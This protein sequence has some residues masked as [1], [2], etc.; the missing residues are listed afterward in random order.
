LAEV[1]DIE[2]LNEIWTGWMRSG[3]SPPVTVVGVSNGRRPMLP[4]GLA[5][6][7]LA[8]IRSGV[9]PRDALLDDLGGA[10]DPDA[11]PVSVIDFLRSYFAPSLFAPRPWRPCV[12][13]IHQV[14][15]LFARSTRVMVIIGA[16]ASVGPDF[17]SPG[18]LY[19]MIAR[20]HAL[21]DPYQV[22]D[23]DYFRQ[24]PTVFWRF[25]HLIFPA[26]EPDHSQTHFFLA[27]LEANGKLL[28]VYSQNVDTL[29]V[30]IPDAKL[31]C[32]HGSWR[33]N[34][35]VEC[36]EVLGIEDLRGRV[37]RQEVPVCKECGGAIKPGIV[38]FGQR[39]NIEDEDIDFDSQNADLLVVIGTSLR[40]AP[41]S[42]LP[43]IMRGIPAVLINREPVTCTFSAEMLGDCDEIC[44]AIEKELGWRDNARPI[45]DFVFAE[46]NKFLLAASGGVGTRFVETGRNLFIVTPTLSGTDYTE[47]E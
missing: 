23:L 43:R 40:V 45:G 32:V 28:R 30:G 26:V 39:T 19:D 36:G 34:Q 41:V 25:A 20:A 4:L 13:D 5:E 16:G 7:I 24:D 14:V 11:A 38:F 21:D 42:Y 27:N 44:Q 31:R 8:A 10:R 1:E 47:L 29:E 12:T 9:G 37:E 35:C 17:R 33:H 18:G 46:P 22:F 3:V 6:R 2:Q 15:D